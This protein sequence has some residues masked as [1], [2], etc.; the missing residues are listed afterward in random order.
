RHPPVEARV[1]DEDHSIRA[2]LAEAPV[3]LAQEPEEQPGIGQH[4]P[5]AHDRQAAQRVKEAAARRFHA[6]A[7]EADAHGP[8]I[9]LPQPPDQ[10]AAVQ[11]AAG[12]AGAEEHAHG[13]S[14]PSHWVGQLS[15]KGP[16]GQCPRTN[17]QGMP[18]ANDPE[19]TPSIAARGLVIL[20]SLAPG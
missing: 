20:W 10:V 11:I 17:H 7:A 6:L 14:L 19:Q 15:R 8:R 5:D 3:S 13:A 16:R 9:A 2:L 12:L 18:I 1:V 4:A